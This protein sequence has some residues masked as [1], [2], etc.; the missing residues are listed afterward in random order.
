MAYLSQK[1]G[2]N[3]KKYAKT[4]IIHLVFLHK[5]YGAKHLQ[6]TL[7]RSDLYREYFPYQLN[8]GQRKNLR[9]HKF[10]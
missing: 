9:R 5:F 4:L 2:I 7:K 10:Y 6:K 1:I 3:I 8:Y